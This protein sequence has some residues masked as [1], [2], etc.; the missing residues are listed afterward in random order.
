MFQAAIID[1]VEGAK[2]KPKKAFREKPAPD[3]TDPPSVSGGESRDEELGGQGKSN[4]NV[5]IE[6]FNGRLR[7][8][9]LI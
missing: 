3:D 2:A 9:C 5:Y 4:K 7:D 6:S 8:E 1:P